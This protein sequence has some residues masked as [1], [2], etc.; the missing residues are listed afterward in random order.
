MLCIAAFFANKKENSAGEFSYCMLKLNLCSLNLTGAETSGANVNTLRRAIYD[1]FNTLNI[2][3][4]RLVG[5]TV[6]MGNL[7]TKGN[8]F[9]AYFT[10]G[11]DE[12][13]LIY[14]NDIVS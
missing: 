4:E 10:F 7:N 1:C 13:L 6:G 11:H 12:H 9:A 2:G 8:A 14:A 3:L 5:A